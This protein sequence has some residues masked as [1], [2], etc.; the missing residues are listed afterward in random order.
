MTKL[1]TV[2]WGSLCLLGASAAMADDEPA[3]H[4]DG[5]AEPYLKALHAKVH[6]LWTDSFLV[7]AEGQLPKDHPINVPSRAAELEVVL[8][9]KGKLA[10]VKLGK[11]S[12]SD[13]FDSSAVDVIK[14]AVPFGA[15]P[16]EVLS[17]DGQAHI[18]WTLARDHRRCSGASID[19][20]TSPLDEGVPMLVAQGR[21]D[22]ALERL[23]TA[24]PAERQVAFTRFARAWL[25]RAENDDSL[26]VRVAV[27]NARAGDDRG[28]ERLRKAIAKN[29]QVELAGQGLRLLK[30]GWCTLAKAPEGECLAA[31]IGLAKNRQAPTTER[32]LAIEGLGKRD[33]PDAKAAL[34]ELLK[35]SA[36]T[37]RAAAIGADARPGAGKG[38]V[39]RLT[40]LLRD[41][42][43]EVRSAAAAALVRVGGDDVLAQLFLLFKE[44]DVR[45][46][47]AVARALGGLTGEPSA[48]LLGRFLRKD[49][50]RIQLAGARALARRHDP[51]AQAAKAPLTR[52]TDAE[53][54]FLAA[55][56]L[57]D[58]EQRKAAAE[59]S[60]GTTWNDSFIALAEGSGKP[61]ALDWI[62]A[63]FPKLAPETRIDLMGA[64][65]GAGRNEN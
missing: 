47:Q 31:T 36:P 2:F 58:A 11:T 65:L 39:F 57:A 41:P 56:L 62:L 60:E 9:S 38:A 12:G 6:R 53:L 25:D 40:A 52:G 30:T 24:D 5:R 20:Q 44:K 55:P 54:R 49:D 43:I 32:T 35:D 46:Y 23:R 50:R 26:A 22:V 51:A 8:T 4:A 48:Q 59:S 14:A 16:D 3:I 33:E 45:P 64:W 21:E 15:A 37:I 18:R 10:Q 42:S 29:E 63:Q 13:D 34:K 61:S 7:M 19:I 1:A 28:A 27:A 17:D